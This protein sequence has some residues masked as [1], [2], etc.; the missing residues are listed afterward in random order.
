MA[1]GPRRPLPIE[2]PQRLAAAL[3]ALGERERRVIELRYGLG[4]R[5]HSLRE[6]GELLSVSAGRVRQIETGAL[7][8]LADRR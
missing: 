5:R 3:E 4:G 1:V 8:R 6:V 7:N 2:H